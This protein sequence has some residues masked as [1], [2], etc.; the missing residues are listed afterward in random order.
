MFVAKGCWLREDDNT[1]LPPSRPTPTSASPSP[2]S[3]QKTARSPRYVRATDT[4][5]SRHRLVL[6]CRKVWEETP[7]AALSVVRCR[8]PPCLTAPS[9]CS[10]VPIT[11]ARTWTFKV[12]V[13]GAWSRDAP[14]SL[15]KHKIN[16]TLCHLTNVHPDRFRG[17]ISGEIFRITSE[18]ESESHHIRVL[19]Y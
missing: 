15:P 13:G 6:P 18:S 17:W 11:V 9:S 5:P 19:K 4:A 12:K 2:A 14:G 16:L 1:F 7:R 3:E 10:S 8:T